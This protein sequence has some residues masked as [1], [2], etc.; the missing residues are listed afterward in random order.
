MR[1]VGKQYSLIYVKLLMRNLWQCIQEEELKTFKVTK[2]TFKLTKSSFICKLRPKQ[3]HKTDPRT[4]AW[5]P[6]PT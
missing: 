6:A 2:T 4:C 1:N 3:F 5:P